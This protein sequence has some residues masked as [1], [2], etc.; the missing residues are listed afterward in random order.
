[1]PVL[2][3][4]VKVAGTIFRHMFFGETWLD[5]LSGADTPLALRGP[6][7]TGQGRPAGA[8]RRGCPGGSRD[9]RAR[10]ARR[11]RLVVRMSHE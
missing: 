10:I 1:M 4:P 7:G 11:V 2:M 6:A 3:A 8:P 5:M 9:G